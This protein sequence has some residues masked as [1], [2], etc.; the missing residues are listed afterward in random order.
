MKTVPGSRPYGRRVY[1]TGGREGVRVPVREI[2]LEAPNAPVRLYDTRGPYGD[3]DYR[4]DLGRADRAGKPNE[5]QRS[6]LG[7]DGQAH[8]GRFADSG[9]LQ[10]CPGGG[11][12]VCEP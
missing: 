5:S 7:Q 1:V 6:A 2:P 3:P 11:G 10:R 4:A 12:G 8:R 9:A